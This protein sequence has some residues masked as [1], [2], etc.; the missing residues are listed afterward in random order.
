MKV[1]KEN[2]KRQL[3]LAITVLAVSIAFAL[4]GLAQNAKVEDSA[5]RLTNKVRHELVML[6]LYG[7][8]DN[9]EFQLQGYDTVLLSG[10]VARP[11]LKNDAENAVRRLEGVANV[12]NNIEVLPLSPNDD[13]IRSAAY[14]T[15]YYR[16]GL[17]RYGLPVV[18]PIHIVVKNG[19]ITLVGLVANQ[20]DKDMAGIVAEGIPGSFSVT[21]NLRVVSE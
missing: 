8:F 2:L 19:D 6:P 14:R 7:V 13:R 10:Q 15:I 18:P 3:S 20:A 1:Q 16:P 5:S 11:S 9:L 4:P 12:V 21:N 17:D